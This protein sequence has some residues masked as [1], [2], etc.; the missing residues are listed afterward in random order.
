[1]PPA[2]PRKMSAS[3]SCCEGLGAIVDVQHD[4][5]RSA[6]L[7]LVVVAQR[8]D[9]L[10][11][12]EVDG[13]VVPVEDVPG[14][15]SVTDTVRGR[16]SRYATNGTAR[17]D[18]VA[19]AALEVRAATRHSTRDPPLA[20]VVPS[21]RERRT[22]PVTMTTR[23]T[24]RARSWREEYKRSVDQIEEGPM[25]WRLEGNYFENCSCDTICPCTWS[26]LT[27]SATHDRCL[28]MLAFHIDD[29]E[30]EGVDVSEPDVRPGCRLPTRHGRR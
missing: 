15:A 5:P 9:D 11:V 7:Y 28:A 25:A 21:L 2:R 23:S 14:E 27:A 18:G 6:R 17:T 12:G 30:V 3:A 22:P 26:G 13:P 20:T 8:Q 24:F 29:G 1:M 19:V 4:L 16:T 10:E